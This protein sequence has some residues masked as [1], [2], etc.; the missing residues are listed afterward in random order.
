LQIEVLETAALED[1]AGVSAIIAE[2]KAFGM[3]FALDDF[4]TGYSSMSYLS[5]FDVD[6]LKIDQSFIRDMLQDK[7]DHAIVLGIIALAKAF[8]M[9]IVAEG[10]ET[11]AQYQ[12][13]LLMGCELGQGYGI[14]RPMT[15]DA[16][17]EWR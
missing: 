15:A 1:V 12:A 16:L 14:A 2:C 9:G 3:A 13:L 6:V 17:L 4:G 5:K 7:G 10:V 8:E 11:E